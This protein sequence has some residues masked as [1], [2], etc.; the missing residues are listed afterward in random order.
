MTVGPPGASAPPGALALAGVVEAVEDL[1]P[2]RRVRLLVDRPGEPVRRIGVA[3]AG[4]RA[5]PPGSR[6]TAQFPA[7]AVRPLRD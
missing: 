2:L 5:L 6:A 7:D 1:G 3:A 4:A